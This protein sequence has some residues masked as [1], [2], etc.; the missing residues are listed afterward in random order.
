MLQDLERRHCE[1]KKIKP[2][3]ADTDN[4][5]GKIGINQSVNVITNYVHTPPSEK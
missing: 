2:Q 3:L 4:L 1:E 5:I